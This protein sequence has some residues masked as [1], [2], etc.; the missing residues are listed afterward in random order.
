[1]FN[2]TEFYLTEKLEG[3]AATYLL[4]KGKYR[5]FS[6]NV[7]VTKAGHT[8]WRKISIK[9]NLENKLRQYKKKHKVE[10]AV[11]GEIV[12]P[13]IQRNIY[14][15]DELKLF[16]YKI[17]NTKTGEAFNLLELKSICEELDL[18]MVPY[19]GIDTLERFNTLE[20]VLEYSN[21]T[22]VLNNKVMREGIVW[23]SVHNQSI[24]FKAKS[25]EYLAWFSKKDTTE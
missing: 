12:G 5:F 22:S 6:H 20:E 11:Q 19:L 3:Q 2:E 7:E 4:Q 17:T 9:Y 18:E 15:L 8:N 24:G 13:G 16:V 21:G 1:M 14:G 10:L 25:P 23:R